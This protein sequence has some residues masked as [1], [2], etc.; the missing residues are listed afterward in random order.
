[1]E[2]DAEAVAILSRAKWDFSGPPWPPSLS[3]ARLLET[4]RG[5]PGR[6]VQKP[7]PPLVAPL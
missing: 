6:E 3:A 2:E 7:E 4:R 1:M 5:G